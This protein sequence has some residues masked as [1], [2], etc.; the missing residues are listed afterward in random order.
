[1]YGDDASL[2][3]DEFMYT[4]APDE[5]V[6][7]VMLYTSNALIRG[8]LVTKASARV[9]IWLR[10]QGQVYYMHIHKA[11]VL[12]FGGP[13]TKS[14]SYDE[15]HLPFSQVIGFHLASAG[16]EPLDYDPDE[17]NRAMKDVLIA[18]GNF[19]VSGKVR[20]STHADF[21]TSI[22]VAHAGWLSVYDAEIT[23][24]FVPQFPAFHA[25]MMLV[26]PMVVSFGI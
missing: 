21:A 5:K 7:T 2:I 18:L 8:E 6:T 10:M 16:D 9:N 24:L 13:L 12:N 4:L 19:S 23:T 11:Q 22:E 20:I 14:L 26:N 15:M 1:M 25:P 17:P 3:K